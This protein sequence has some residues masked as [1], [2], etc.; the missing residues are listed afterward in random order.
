MDEIKK[1][2]LNKAADVIYDH[3]KNPDLTLETIADDLQRITE[4][5]LGN[6]MTSEE[7]IAA[8]EGCDVMSAEWRR[9]A[10]KLKAPKLRLVKPK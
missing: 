6:P 2:A 7:M 4:R 1:A 3:A 5:N 10:A 9:R 8:A